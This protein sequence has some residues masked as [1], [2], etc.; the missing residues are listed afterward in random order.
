MKFVIPNNDR[1]SN[2]PLNLRARDHPP[3]NAR[4][5]FA[6]KVTGDIAI[7]LHQTDIRKPDSG[8]QFAPGAYLLSA[9][10]KITHHGPVTIR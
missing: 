7:P 6:L 4:V 3:Q 5:D 10:A 1:S 2:D 8:S 9:S